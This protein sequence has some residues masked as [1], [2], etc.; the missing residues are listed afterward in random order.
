MTGGPGE[1]IGKLVWTDVL[2]CTDFVM[3]PGAGTDGSRCR[4]VLLSP[5]GQDFDIARQSGFN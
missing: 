2:R 1:L 3:L 5:D 4:A